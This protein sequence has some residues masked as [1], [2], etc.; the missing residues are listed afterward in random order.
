[1]PGS[2][3]W[4]EVPVGNADHTQAAVVIIGA[5]IS[6]MCMAIDLLKRNKFQNFIILE[7]S[8][9]VGGIHFNFID[10]MVSCANGCY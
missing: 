9:G 7:R 6:G 10:L 5:G 8:S 2:K 3:P 4:P 1:M